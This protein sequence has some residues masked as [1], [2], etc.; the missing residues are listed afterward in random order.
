MMTDEETADPEHVDAVTGMLAVGGTLARCLAAK[1]ADQRDVVVQAGKRLMVV[2][3]VLADF[4]DC[5][6]VFRRT[7][8]QLDA[9]RLEPVDR[10]DDEILVQLW[11]YIVDTYGRDRAVLL[12]CRILAVG[13]SPQFIRVSQQVSI[14]IMA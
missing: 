4:E 14:D 5:W 13:S 3:R 1:P 8:R 9:A 6:D 7:I 12:D 11:Q 2:R 10:T